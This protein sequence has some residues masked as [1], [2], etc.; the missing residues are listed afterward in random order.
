MWA[1]STSSEISTAQPW[2]ALG[3]DPAFPD[4]STPT[5]SNQ[6]LL[7]PGPAEAL[8]ALLDVHV[9]DLDNGAGL[10]LLW[11]WVYLLDRP[12]QADLGPDGHPM[13]GT[14]TAPPGPGR[15]RMWAGGELE[16]FDALRVGDEAKRASRITDVTMKAGGTGTLCFVSV[17]HAVRTSRGLDGGRCRP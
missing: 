5:L 3:N 1:H 11:H 16:F 12:A 6:G 13:H 9:P 17:A 4:E 10:P 2:S 15:R 14:V 7:L 8:G